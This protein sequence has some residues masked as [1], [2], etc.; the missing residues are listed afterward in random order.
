MLLLLWG[1]W[2]WCRAF[3]SFSLFKQS[4]LNYD[5]VYLSCFLFALLFSKAPE[6]SL[7]ITLPYFGIL[8]SLRFLFF[9]VF[10]LQQRIEIMAPILLPGFKFRLFFMGS[11]C[12]ILI[13][14][15]IWHA[16]CVNTTSLLKLFYFRFWVL[17]KMKGP[18]TIWST[19]K[20]SYT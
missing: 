1:P 3:S 20:T 15:P 9:C 7:Q 11:S 4:V 2:N 14:S 6:S 16:S 18:S 13:P 12:S 19:W 10:H 17:W 8:L 5:L